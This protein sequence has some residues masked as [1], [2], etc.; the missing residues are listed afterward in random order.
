[1]Q[2]PSMTDVECARRTHFICDREPA[3]CLAAE[4]YLDFASS[5]SAK[6][7]IFVLLCSRPLLYL[8]TRHTTSCHW[9]ISD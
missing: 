5:E 2:S 1:M 4:Q 8:A 9:T 6:A 3:Q 7:C